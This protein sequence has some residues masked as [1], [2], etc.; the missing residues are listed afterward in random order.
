[1]KTH[2]SKAVKHDEYSWVGSQ[3]GFVDE[4]R[5]YKIRHMVLGRFGGNSSSHWP[6]KY[7]IRF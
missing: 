3:E 6:K 5:I 7:A 4:I 2:M 1:M